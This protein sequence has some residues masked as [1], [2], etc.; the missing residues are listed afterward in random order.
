MTVLCTFGMTY[1]VPALDGSILHGNSAPF[2]SL[3]GPVIPVVGQLFPQRRKV[4]QGHC[5]KG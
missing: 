5:N 3:A 2:F 4:L 1:A